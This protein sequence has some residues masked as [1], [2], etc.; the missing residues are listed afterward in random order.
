MSIILSGT[1]M[2]RHFGSF[3]AVRN[4]S[5]DLRTGE[6]L[7]IVGPNGAGKTTLFSLVAGSLAPS[8]GT[9]TLEGRDVTRIDAASR[10]LAGLGRTHQVPRPFL[11]MSV[12]E[13]ALVAAQ[14]GSGLHEE[15]AEWAA[16]EAI[17]RS[18]LLH[19]ANKPAAA[20]GLLDR[21]SCFWTRSAA[22]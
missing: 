18:G 16:A 11:G 3:H 19:L 10:C 20:L 17:E 21:R 9:I 8:S 2:N 4:V 14:H 5:F 15:E 13:N 12:F 7:G 22:A 6:A 1:E